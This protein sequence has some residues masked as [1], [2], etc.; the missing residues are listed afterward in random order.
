LVRAKN[1]SVR[2]DQP[3]GAGR[4]KDIDEGAGLTIEPQYLLELATT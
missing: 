1:Y 2:G 3:A 4:N